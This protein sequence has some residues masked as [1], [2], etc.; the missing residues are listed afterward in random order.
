MREGPH[1]WRGP[2]SPHRQVSFLLSAL[3]SAPLSPFSMH[4][5]LQPSRTGGSRRADAVPGWPTL[6]AT[7]AIA[8]VLVVFAAA[9]VM[10]LQSDFWW[11]LRAGQEMWSRHVL[12][13][14]DEFSFTARGN[15]WPNHEWLSEI[16]LFLAYR[17]AGLPGVTLLAAGCVTAATAL[18]WRLTPGPATSKLLIM[19]A[20]I[21]SLVFVWTVRP[22]V[23]TL[24][25]LMT[26]MSL[27]LRSRYWALPCVFAIW[28]NLHGGV[29]LGLVALGAA[30]L[31][32]LW[33]GDRKRA[34]QLLA[35]T[36]ICFAA[37]L[38]TPLGL[39]L[40]KT[41]P[42]SIQKS[43]ANGIQEWRPPLLLGWRDLSFW[44]FAVA[45]LT[46]VAFRWRRM[47]TR[48]Q[49][50]PVFVALALLP[51]AL[52]YSRNITPFMLV[53]VPALGSLVLADVRLERAGRREHYAFNRALIAACVLACIGG[54]LSAWSSRAPRMH[55][56]PVSTQIVAS[57]RACPGRLY[58][59]FDDGG[60][61][62]WFAPDIPVFVDNRQDPYALPFLQDHLQHEQS[63]DYASVFE[64][65]SL[66]CAFLPP[67]SPTA[68]NLQAAG[69]TIA[70][71]D[72]NWLVLQKQ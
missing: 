32:E 66:T 42:E 63:G 67:S 27:V 58:N 48:E 5:T 12:A 53:A 44:V 46:A 37:T 54:V 64:R 39:D 60:Y 34:R 31:A 15:Y 19:A 11:H 20:A 38:M 50:I 14:S 16:A 26:C 24:A 9:C 10:P 30:T 3:S 52:R 33:A 69:W 6:D 29:A 62:I 25:L 45:T 4:Q 23:F 2:T 72:S 71:A 40:W 59:R 43:M 22:H 49:A 35:I 36:V 17:A 61:L 65:Y 55:W 57:V 47:T 70:A 28:A 8:F 13:L 41:I 51:L 18:S 68:K 7:I 21:P 1:I 56:Q